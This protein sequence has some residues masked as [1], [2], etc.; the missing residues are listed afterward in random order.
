MAEFFIGMVLTML[1]G[2]ITGYLLFIPVGVLMRRDD[3][4]RHPQRASTA[5]PAPSPVPAVAQRVTQPP[6]VVN[7]HLSGLPQR[8]PQPR[9]IDARYDEPVPVPIDLDALQDT[10][11]QA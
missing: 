2:M 8:G 5:V 3:Y 4:C 1:P 10:R 6:V 11:G 7:L 9:V